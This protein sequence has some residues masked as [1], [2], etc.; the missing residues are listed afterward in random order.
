MKAIVVGWLKPVTTVFTDR[1][2]SSMDGPLDCVVTKVVI[3]EELLLVSGS[4]S[5]AVTLAVLLNWAV[6]C[7]MITIV[8]VADAS[9]AR[10]P[11]LH[12]M[13]VVPL[14]IPCVGVAE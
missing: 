13:V 5:V 3:D 9:L 8:T 12:V 10:L 14:H 6:D 7:G 1:F 11:K 2:E 4:V